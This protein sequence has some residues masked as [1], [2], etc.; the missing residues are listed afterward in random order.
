MKALATDQE[1]CSTSILCMSYWLKVIGIEA[2]FYPAEMVKLQSMR[3]GT[4][5]PF[6]RIDMDIPL[7]KWRAQDAI[8]GITPRS[9]P[10][11]DPAS[12]VINYDPGP[13]M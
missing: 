2:E 4:D 11:P 10:R 12:I 1:T 5:A 7:A 3:H 9:C 8:L 13:Y 6:V